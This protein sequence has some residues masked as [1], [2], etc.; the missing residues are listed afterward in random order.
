MMNR[1]S[2]LK[3]LTITVKKLLTKIAEFDYP[4]QNGVINHSAICEKY[5][6]CRNSFLAG[7]NYVHDEQAQQV[8][9]F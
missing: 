9:F 2:E 6:T 4:R 5:E 1:P 3:N 7:N 8:N